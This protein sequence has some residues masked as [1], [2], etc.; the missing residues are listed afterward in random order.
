MCLVGAF[1]DSSLDFDGVRP[2]GGANVGDASS[3][4]SQ[5][6]SAL[7]AKISASPLIIGILNG[8][9]NASITSFIVNSTMEYNFITHGIPHLSSI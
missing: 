4:G 1:F 5:R 7:I 2:L 3:W 9:A 8:A 6:N